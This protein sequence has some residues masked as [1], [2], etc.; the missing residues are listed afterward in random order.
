MSAVRAPDG[1]GTRPRGGR[2]PQPPPRATP[3]G[4]PHLLKIFAQL[5][6][7]VHLPVSAGVAGG[8]QE[9]GEEAP[10]RPPCSGG[11]GSARGPQCWLREGP[12]CSAR[13]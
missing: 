2:A 12:V 9:E 13:H 6:R 7:H 11:A 8:Q 5:G 4:R 10:Q 1:G 3:R